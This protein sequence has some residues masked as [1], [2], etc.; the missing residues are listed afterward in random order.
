MAGR[1]GGLTRRFNTVEEVGNGMSRPD[2]DEAGGSQITERLTQREN[3]AAALNEQGYTDILVLRRATGRE[4]LTQSRLELVD[5]LDTHGD[6]VVSVSDLARG[7][8]RDKGAVSKDLQRLSELDV[9]AYEGEGNGDA[10]RPMLKHD[11]IVVEP[12]RY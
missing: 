5:Y 6:D 11:T 2:A 8:D 10:K 9:V 7:L 4:I 12:I 3:F 1:R